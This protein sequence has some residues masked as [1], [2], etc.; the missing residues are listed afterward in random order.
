MRIIADLVAEIRNRKRSISDVLKAQQQ[1]H[2]GRRWSVY[3]VIGNAR[4]TH[5]DDRDKA[6]LWHA[7]RANL[8]SQPAGIRLAVD[9]MKLARELLESNR[10]GSDIA[11]IAAAWSARYWLEEE[12]HHE[13]A[14]GVLLEM[15][16]LEPI[17]PD[18]VV[19]QRGFFPSDNYAR[20]CMLQACAEIEATVMHGEIAKTS[21]DPVIREV[22]HRIMQDEVEHRQYFVS[23]AK[24]LLDS[25]VYP[26][27]DVMHVAY[28]W[29]RP[30]GGESHGRKRVGQTSRDGFV[31]WQGYVLAD[32]STG[33]APPDDQMRSEPLRAKKVRSVLAAVQD[34]TGIPLK[35][36]TELE[37]AYFASLA[38][39]DI[40]RLRRAVAG[41][42]QKRK[43]REPRFVEIHMA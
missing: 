15:A 14:Y 17:A 34:A 25:G 7:A 18:E 27:K 13:A 16:G 24:G 33:V 30:S 20:V 26:I 22:F 5:V 6:V 1:Y 31:N 29:I 38:T 37:L 28:T 36:I 21:R 42:V 4:L 41:G 2:E 11:H 40:D 39:N 35:S 32:H 19:L 23:F 43:E 8:T 10:L 9:G 12:A 3:D